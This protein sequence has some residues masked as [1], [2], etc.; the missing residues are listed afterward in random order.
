ML[1]IP[2]LNRRATK[3]LAHFVAAVSCL[4]TEKPQVLIDDGLYD[5]RRSLAGCAAAFIQQL[6]DSKQGI[7]DG[8]HGV[9]AARH[10]DQHLPIVAAVELQRLAAQDDAHVGIRQPTILERLQKWA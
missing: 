3:Q 9:F 4:H 1:K 7:A 8:K 5:A 6:V 2:L 10:A